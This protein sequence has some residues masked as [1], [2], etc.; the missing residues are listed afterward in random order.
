MYFIIMHS[1]NFDDFFSVNRI[2]YRETKEGILN[3]Y[4]LMLD[5]TLKRIKGTSSWKG[6]SLWYRL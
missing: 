6:A 1:S 2:L 4:M 5:E 3:N